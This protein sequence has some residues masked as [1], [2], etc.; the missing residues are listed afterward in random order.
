MFELRSIS[1]VSWLQQPGLGR[2]TSTSDFE[3]VLREQL[4]PIL[5]VQIPPGQQMTSGI[6]CWTRRKS[7]KRWSLNSLKSVLNLT[8]NFRKKLQLKMQNKKGTNC[9]RS[10]I[11]S[12]TSKATSSSVN[13]SK[14]LEFTT[15]N[16]LASPWIVRKISC[17]FFIDQNSTKLFAPSSGETLFHPKPWRKQDYFLNVFIKESLSS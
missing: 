14:L 5:V 4:V 8:E 16:L 11:S 9:P 1:I 17:W 12:A 6:C 13:P 3:L 2:R 7:T 15:W 10:L